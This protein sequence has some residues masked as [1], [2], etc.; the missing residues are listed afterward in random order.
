MKRV[1]ATILAITSAS[2]ALACPSFGFSSP[3]LSAFFCEDLEDIAPPVTRSMDITD[4]ALTPDQ[5]DQLG[6]D[7][8]A[9]PRVE[10]AWRADPAKTLRLIQRIR[11]AG[12]RPVN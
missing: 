11:D 3:H 8:L 6:P 4:D 5:E 1:L 2:G 12:G 9:L 10:R 7:W